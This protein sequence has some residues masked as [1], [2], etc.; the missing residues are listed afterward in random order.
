MSA[1]AQMSTQTPMRRDQAEQR[2]RLLDQLKAYL[3]PE[4]LGFLAENGVIEILL[5]ADGTLWVERLGCAME[6]F[7]RIAPHQ[8]RV[9]LDSIAGLVGTT[10]TSDNPILEC[11]FPIDDS[12][13]E[14]LIPPVVSAPTFAL[15]MKP[16]RIFSLDDYEMSG[17]L[18][19]AQRQAIVAAV[20]D[21]ANILVV[22]GTGSGKTTLTNAILHAMSVE[23]PDDRI[24]IIEDT[25]ELMCA[26]ANHQV[27]RA[28][29]AVSMLKLL[30]VTMRLRPDRIVVGE[31]R[32]EEALALLKAWNTGHPGGVA[33]VHANGGRAGLL[34]M[35][36]LVAEATFAPMQEMIATAVNLVVV[37]AKTPEGRR[38]REI[39]RV[40]GYRDG[41]YLT[42]A[43]EG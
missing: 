36:S 33:T 34:R 15:R 32:G 10:L 41:D 20:R 18:S 7:G 9:I 4:I 13:F 17:A 30:K 3:G 22:G 28:T 16:S 43:I 37:I 29:A 12:R 19:G 26:A 5:N 6:C 2:T 14:A 31:V 23:T 42:Q 21:H 40:T 38:I 8:G 1:A 27:L 25:A 24:V 39:L 11:E 35:Q